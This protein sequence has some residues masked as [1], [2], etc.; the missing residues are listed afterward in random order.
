VELVAS[1][2]RGLIERIGKTYA[3]RGI[4]GD[5]AEARKQRD[6]A[7]AKFEK[8]LADLRARVLSPK[9]NAEQIALQAQ[10]WNDFK[11]VHLA[12]PTKEGATQLT[13]TAEE[14]AWVA[15][16]GA[17]MVGGEKYQGPAGEE[18]AAISQRLARIYLFQAY[19]VKV[20]FLPKDL[21]EARADF[22]KAVKSAR[23]KSAKDDAMLSKL[24]LLESQFAFFGHAIDQL[25][26]D[27]ANPNLR[28][29][30]LTSSERIY[31]LAMALGI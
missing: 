12:P 26:K 28:R 7:I 13:D 10:I 5:S 15:Q 25:T 8:N 22:A 4:E 1:A 24:T 30:V 6:E 18:V 21:A 17:Q 3:W 9:E 29:N 2:Q 16:K 31:E 23:D 20:A 14:L 27:N 11:A 19:G